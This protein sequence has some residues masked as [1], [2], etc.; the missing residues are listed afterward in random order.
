MAG[1]TQRVF[2]GS[3]KAAVEFGKVQYRSPKWKDGILVEPSAAICQVTFYGPNARS[4]LSALAEF[5]DEGAVTLD[6][7]VYRELLM[8]VPASAQIGP[9]ATRNKRQAN[10]PTVREVCEITGI[11]AAAIDIRDGLVVNRQTGEIIEVDDYALADY[12]AAHKG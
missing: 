10:A 9:G 6:A 4:L 3:V 5:A 7:N 8:D 1:K 2:E 12:R 11:D